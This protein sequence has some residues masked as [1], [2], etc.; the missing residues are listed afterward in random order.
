M[1][2][3]DLTTPLDIALDDH[4]AARA[5]SSMQHNVSDPRVAESYRAFIAET[6]AQWRDVLDEIDVDFIEGEPYCFEGKPSSAE[7]FRDLDRGHLLTRLTIQ[8]GDFDAT[9]AD[10]FMREPH[11]LLVMNDVFRAVHDV[12]GHYGGEGAKHY[13]FG[14]NGERNAWIR[15]R[16]MY[17]ETAHLALWCE[18]RGQAASYAVTGEFAPQKCGYVHPAMV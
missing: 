11:G 13:S 16:R 10:H 15:H 17:S 7:M 4:E 5:Y 18:T 12:N 2:T 3:L 9:P 6:L 14:P 8:S 1:H